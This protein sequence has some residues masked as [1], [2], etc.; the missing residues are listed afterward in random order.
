MDDVIFA[1][2]GKPRLLDVA[3]RLVVNKPE[4]TGIAIVARW[5]LENS[6]IFDGRRFCIPK[7]RHPTPIQQ[8]IRTSL[9]ISDDL[10][11]HK[12]SPRSCFGVIG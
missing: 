6:L 11:R 1:H 3:A 4:A 8:T 10:R 12:Q 5:P 9:A 2:T 7:F